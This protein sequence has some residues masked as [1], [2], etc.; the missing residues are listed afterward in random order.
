VGRLTGWVPPTSLVRWMS[1][2][3]GRS[4]RF[5]LDCLSSSLV[6]SLMFWR[7]LARGLV[8]VSSSLSVSMASFLDSLEAALWF[9]SLLLLFLGRADETAQSGVGYRRSY[10]LRS[11]LVYSLP[12]TISS[13]SL[14]LSFRSLELFA[15][16]TV[17]RSSSLSSHAAFGFP[18]EES[19]LSDASVSMIFPS[20]RLSGPESR[21]KS[22]RQ[23]SA[24]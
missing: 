8:V 13:A 2:T 9:A 20:A 24:I 12:L 18:G 4:F 23:P 22:Y 7:S 6:R 3:S 10:C 15:R 17:I 16:E 11:L 21:K 19:S 14:T 1:R 5:F